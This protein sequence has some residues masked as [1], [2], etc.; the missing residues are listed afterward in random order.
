LSKQV[1]SFFDDRATSFDS[2]Y[3]NE[4]RSARAV[5][6]LFRR[7]IYT[8]FEIAMRESG[9]VTGKSVLDVGCGSGRYC[10]EYARRGAEP[11]VGIDIAPSMLALARKLAQQEQVQD[12]CEFV[13]AE[14]QQVALRRRFD[15]VL[16]MGFFDYVTEPVDTLGKMVQVSKHLVLASFPGRNLIRMHLRAPRYRLQNCPLHFYTETELHELCAAVDLSKYKLVFIPHSGT[17]FVLVGDCS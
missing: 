1:R 15:V 3:L 12:R 9:D 8:R 5:N 16:A 13:E 17:G 10:I 11:V 14:F 2:I 4:S 6:R 7:A